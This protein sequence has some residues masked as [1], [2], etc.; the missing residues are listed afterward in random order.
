MTNIKFNL[1]D[2]KIFC[3]RK[4]EKKRKYFNSGRGKKPKGNGIKMMALC[5]GFCVFIRS[6][7]A[8][9]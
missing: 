7:L 8:A 1:I 3:K 5:V 2:E 4:K 9:P 6:L